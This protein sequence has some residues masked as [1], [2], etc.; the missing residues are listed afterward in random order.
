MSRNGPWLTIAAAALFIAPCLYIVG[1]LTDGPLAGAGRRLASGSDA[2]G[3][4]KGARP[5]AASLEPGSRDVAG[6][7]GGRSGDG[8]GDDSRYGARGSRGV[9]AFGRGSGP[10]RDADGNVVDASYRNSD[11]SFGRAGQSFDP[12]DLSVLD[13]IIRLNGLTE[14]SSSFDYDDGDGVLEPT[15]LGRQ[16]WC[17]SRLR[18]LQMGPDSFATFGYEVRELPDTL[19]NLE[20]L[21]VL[22][23]NQTGLEALPEALGQM[24]SLERVSAF[25][26][27][28]KEIPSSL[29][30]S[31]RLEELQ[32]N[33][34]EIAEIPAEVQQKRG[35]KGVFVEGNPMAAMPRM[36]QKQY[37][38]LMKGKLVLAPREVG[39]FGPDCRVL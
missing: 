10:S 34:N 8:S 33:A 3:T 13:D 27:R 6:R 7:P 2:A 23:S 29:A 25:G 18:A 9:Y 20:F 30:Q 22:E 32:L 16:V 14:E 24:P 19:A 39:A 4:A 28:V 26:N 1:D 37:E 11:P 36:V 17:G 5:G 35:L 31:E 21:V 15:E 12:R 38:S